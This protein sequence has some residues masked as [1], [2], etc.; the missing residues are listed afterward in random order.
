MRVYHYS[1]P[2]LDLKL[3][4]LSVPDDAVQRFKHVLLS[5]EKPMHE[6]LYDVLT[7]CMAGY[8]TVATVRSLK[9]EYIQICNCSDSFARSESIQSFSKVVESLYNLP[10]KQTYSV[11]SIEREIRY[12]NSDFNVGNW[13]RLYMLE[14]KVRALESK[15]GLQAMPKD[16]LKEFII[17]TNRLIE[18]IELD[19]LTNSADN[20]WLAMFEKDSANMFVF[21]H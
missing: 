13:S 12:I 1:S 15:R 3:R 17:L 11:A 7:Q 19:V 6:Y 14:D 21:I 2:H 18:Q 16:A 8:G 20:S 4:S 10:T 9:D 5:L